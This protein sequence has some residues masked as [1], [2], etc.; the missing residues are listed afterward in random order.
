MVVG[1][2]MATEAAEYAAPGREDP[3]SGLQSNGDEVAQNMVIS[4]EGHAVEEGGE[5]NCIAWQNTVGG[6]YSHREKQTPNVRVRGN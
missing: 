2:A 6:N 1:E 4:E 5:G 3:R